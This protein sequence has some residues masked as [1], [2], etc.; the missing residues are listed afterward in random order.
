MKSMIFD[1]V[2]NY[3]YRP[4]VGVGSLVGMLKTGYMHAKTLKL[5]VYDACI[6]PS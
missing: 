3:K 1:I 4:Y 5:K 2:E 6:S